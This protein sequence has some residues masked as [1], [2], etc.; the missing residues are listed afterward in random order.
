M[1]ARARA[2]VAVL[3]LG[4]VLLAGCSS[5]P[6]RPS[7]A[8]LAARYLAI[9]TPAN[10]ALDAS[11][12]ALEDADDDLGGSATLLRNIAATERQFDRDLVALKLPAKLGMTAAAL[13][14]INEARAT[15]TSQAVSASS[16]ESLQRY[17]TELDAMNV[18]VEDQV[19]ALRKQLA[20]P[21]PATD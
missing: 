20:L 18:P 13:V 11:F 1:I 2:G 16:V 8:A 15:M 17:E 4:P 10:E 5:P 21:P 6:S 7:T 3:V 19:R 14:R 12:D 9:A